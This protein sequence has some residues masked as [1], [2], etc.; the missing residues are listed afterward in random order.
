ML[1]LF[2]LFIFTCASCAFVF[3][4]FASFAFRIRDLLSQMNFRLQ[5]PTYIT[6]IFIHFALQCY[7]VD[8]DFFA[9]Q[10]MLTIFNS[11]R[12]ISCDKKMCAI[13]FFKAFQLR[14]TF[15]FIAELF[16]SGR[17]RKEK[18]E[19]SIDLKFKPCIPFFLSRFFRNSLRCY[20][21]VAANLE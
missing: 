5:C 11:S 1:V 4:Q 2:C 8:A 14:L 7:S 19:K 18:R 15:S 20:R 13:E 10:F 16:E 9:P 21:F 3:V 12:N 17:K 6:A